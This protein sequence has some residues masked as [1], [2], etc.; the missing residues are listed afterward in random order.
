MGGFFCKA[1]REAIPNLLN[2]LAHVM[3]IPVSNSFCEGVFSVM[4]RHW[5]DERNRIEI[6]ILGEEICVKHNFDHSC[7]EFYNFIKEQT[8]IR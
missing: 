3:A 2:L 8:T 4:N 5:S 7:S 1:D 6:G